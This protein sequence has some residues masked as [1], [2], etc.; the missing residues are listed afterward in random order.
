[1][2]DDKLRKKEHKREEQKEKQRR[3][4]EQKKWKELQHRKEK[5]EWENTQNN[6]NDNGPPWTDNKNKNNNG[7][8][9]G[10]GH[11]HGHGKNGRFK[12]QQNDMQFGTSLPFQIAFSTEMP[13]NSSTVQFGF[14]SPLPTVFLTDTFPTI[15]STDVP[16][17]SS[18]AFP[19]QFDA[20]ERWPLCAAQIA[21]IADQGTCGS[22]WAIATA[23]MIQ[24]RLCI[25]K[26]EAGI[27]ETNVPISS[28]DILTCSGG[29][30]E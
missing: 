25:Q 15:V 30:D 23:K 1:M 27:P 9:N 19:T 10:N 12:R 2:I 24:D 28:A 17:N 20:R 4:N 13:I 6:A 7:N 3:K 14:S 26:A 11:G 22:C 29:Q 21:I 16:I 8:G 18:T 5:K